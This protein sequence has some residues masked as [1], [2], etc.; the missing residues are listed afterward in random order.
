VVSLS[1]IV[2]TLTDHLGLVPPAGADGAAFTEALTPGGTP[3]G[4]EQSRSASMCCY[5]VRTA[6][7]SLMGVRDPA[8]IDWVLHEQGRGG[9]VS[10]EHPDVV[11]ELSAAVAGWPLDLGD[12]NAL[13]QEP[14]RDRPAL[15]EALQEGGYWRR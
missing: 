15:K 14:A 8:G 2:P 6:G 5:G 10:K 12:V 7:W 1:G 9:D 13:N 3:T 4:T 11:A